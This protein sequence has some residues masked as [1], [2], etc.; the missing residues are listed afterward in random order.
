MGAMAFHTFTPTSNDGFV[1]S[2]HP[3]ESETVQVWI[4][5]NRMK[6]MDSGFRRKDEKR[7]LATSMNSSSNYRL[8]T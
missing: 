4:N 7:T 6:I 2:R 8:F 5:D 1:E 3:G